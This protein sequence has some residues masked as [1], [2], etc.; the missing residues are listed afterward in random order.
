M[1]PLRPEALG[2]CKKRGEEEKVRG[3]ERE[4][5]NWVSEYNNRRT[6]QFNVMA[7]FERALALTLCGASDGTIAKRNK[8]SH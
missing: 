2:G 7:F 3:H 6:S 5:E 8:K 1:I 4:K